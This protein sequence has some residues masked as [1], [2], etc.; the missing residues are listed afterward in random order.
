MQKTSNKPKNKGETKVATRKLLTEDQLK[1]FLIDS[2]SSDCDPKTILN[3]LAE[4]TAEIR[5]DKKMTKN[6]TKE[7]QEEFKSAMPIVAL[8]THY[9][10]A[11]SVGDRYR[12]FLIQFANDITE[13]YDC[14]T[15]SE[16]T[17]AE[18]IA[19]S[20]GRILELSSTFSISHRLDYLSSE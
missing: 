9:L 8:E 10:A 2:L 4:L 6:R 17:L 19:M 11:E 1:K 20:Y 15:P 13:E 7:V 16:R 5:S 3:K 12:T 14:Q 18:S